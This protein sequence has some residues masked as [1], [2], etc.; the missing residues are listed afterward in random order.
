M[1]YLICVVF[2]FLHSLILATPFRIQCDGKMYLG[3][4]L[5]R[6]TLWECYFVNFNFSNNTNNNL[7]LIT[8]KYYW[9]SNLISST[10]FLVPH[11]R[12]GL[13]RINPIVINANA[14]LNIPT[15]LMVAVNSR[16]VSMSKIEFD[17]VVMPDKEYS[18]QNYYHDF[19]YYTKF[20]MNLVHFK[21]NWKR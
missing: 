12:I 13:N 20:K 9:S 6:G 14:S 5:Y 10:E 8:L 21:V 7:M 19:E 1:K 17:Y 3:Q 16:N 4:I 15:I 18:L 11:K 2:I